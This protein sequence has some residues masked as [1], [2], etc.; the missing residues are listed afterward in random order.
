MQIYVKADEMTKRYERKL[1]FPNSHQKPLPAGRAYRFHAMIK[2]AGASCNLDCD[3]CFYLHK[4][5]LLKQPAFAPMSDLVLEQHIRQYI[6]GQTGER[7]IFSW[8]GGEP[9]LMGLGFFEKIINLQ[10]KYKKPHQAIENDLQTNGTLLDEKWMEFLKKNNFHVGLSIDGPKEYHDRF[11]VDK[12]G[13]PTFDKVIKSARLL[14]EYQIP[15][16]ALCVVNRYNSEK[17]RE[18]YRF[19]ANEVGTY[20][21][22]FT[23]AVEPDYFTQ[24]SPQAVD[25]EN[26]DLATLLTPW[27]V[28][29]HGYGD[30]LIEAW[31]EWYKN[32]YGRIHVNIFET[33]VAQSLGMAAQI[34]TTSPFCGKGLA[35]E[36][37]GDVYSCD[38]LVYA[39]YKIGNILQNHE[40]DLAF[41]QKQVQFGLDK[42]EKLAKKCLSCAY[43]NL[44]WG[45][46]PKNR[47]LKMKDD[48]GKLNYL[49]EGLYAFFDH[50]QADLK[51]I[52]K[53]FPA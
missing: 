12:K 10:A 13:R 33:A 47:L 4:T 24:K 25:M 36:H 29:A 39:D 45:E 40:G 2:P 43:K 37:N 27:S 20:R 26:L 44:C 42:N 18:V 52:H 51:E 21:V 11:R 7:V 6:E 15:F 14:R 19:L 46:C 32:D 9:T 23:P 8:Q 1:T 3:Y 53:L 30:F 35:V 22:Q 48:E 41:S 38:H 50:I 28:T 17:P 34:C 49:C 31:D 16:A 5:Q